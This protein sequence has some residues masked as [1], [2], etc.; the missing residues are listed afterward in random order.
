MFRRYMEGEGHARLFAKG[1]IKYV[2]LD[3]L[4][5]HPS[6]GYEVIR[7][8]QDR[9]HGL[10]SPSAGSVYPT[11]Q[12]LEEM[13]YVVSQERDGKKVYSVT[14]R[15]REFL[16]EHS[17]IVHNL[18]DNMR[19]WRGE[20]GRGEIR[21]ILADLRDMARSIGRK[22]RKLDHEQTERIGTIIENAR[23]DIERI[24]SE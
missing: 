18:Q 17:D 4:E 21:E 5:D 14:D 2:I 8:L 7:M 24:F 1:D 15:G 10:Y 22:S 6:H 12:M 9:F 13:E 23:R 19:H 16:S 3:L 11:L 20:M